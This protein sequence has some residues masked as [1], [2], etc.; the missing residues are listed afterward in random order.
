MD[1][2][3]SERPLDQLHLFQQSSQDK[4]DSAAS[5]QAWTAATAEEEKADS[6]PGSE[7]WLP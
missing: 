6:A 3:A 1:E 5:K 7:Y 2:T 4:R